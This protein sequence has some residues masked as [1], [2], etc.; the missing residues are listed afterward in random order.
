LLFSFLIQAGEQLVV[1]LSF[2]SQVPL[3][4]E[5]VPTFAV[6]SVLEWL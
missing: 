6:Q 2:V 5:A 4:Y 1:L 3:P